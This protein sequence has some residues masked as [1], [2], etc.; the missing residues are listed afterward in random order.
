MPVPVGHKKDDLLALNITPAGGS[1]DSLRHSSRRWTMVQPSYTLL[2]YGHFGFGPKPFPHHTHDL[3]LCAYPRYMDFFL[4]V[5]VVLLSFPE[6]RFVHL[7][8]SS[9]LPLPLLHSFSYS[10][11]ASY[12]TL[13]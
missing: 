11:I 5:L 2:L 9:P 7:S 13:P 3:Y 4:P 8:P 6:S 1:T 12:F 10:S